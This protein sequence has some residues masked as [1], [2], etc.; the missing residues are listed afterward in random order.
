MRVPVKLLGFGFWLL[1]LN[2]AQCKEITCELKSTT[3]GVKKINPD[4]KIIFRAR[5][6]VEITC[7]EKHWIFFT[8]ESR[9]TF[10]CKADGKWDNEPVCAE[11]TCD[12]PRDQLVSRPYYWRT[13]K[14][15]EK[16]SYTCVNGYRGTEAEATCT[17]DGWTPKPLCTE[18]LCD[19]PKIKNA[20]IVGRQRPNY[21]I[22]S[23]EE[24]RCLSGFKPEKPVQITCDSQGQWKDIQQCIEITCELKST[25]I[26]VKKIN[27]DG[28]IIFRARESVEITCSEKH[29]IFFTKE[30]R[31]TFTC[32]ADGKWDN[33]PVCA[34]ITCDDPRDQ[35][36]SRPYYWRTMKFGEKQSYTCVNGYRGTEAEATCT[37]DGWTPKPLCT[38]IL[39]DVPKIK[40]A[41]IVGRQRP[42]YRINSK[43]EYRCLSGFKPEKPVQITCDSQGQ[44][45]DIQQCIEIMCDLPKITNAEIMRSQES[46]YKISS[47]VEYKCRSGFEPEK[48]VQI[49]CDSQGQWRGI[50]QCTE[51][52]CDLPKILNAEIL[53]SQKSNFKINSTTKYKCRSGIDAEKPIQITCDS[54]GQ[55]TGIQQCTEKCGPPP[56]ISNADTKEM[57]NKDYN[58]TEKVEYK[59]FDKYTMNLSPPFSKYLTCVKGEWK[60]DIYCFKPCIVTVEEMDKRGIRMRWKAN[61]KM[62]IPHNDAIDFLCKSGKEF[63]STC[64]DGVMLLPECGE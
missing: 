14:L 6:S 36:V 17:R 51:I 20:E 43:E 22:N 7:S 55:W 27:P 54:Q 5:E 2:F 58:T 38:E 12:D 32:K 4:G 45:K 13:M 57:T 48:P 3:I 56:E 46:N 28:K 37:R 41:E 31:K 40:N 34:E 53:G 24:Y 21:R 39:C 18:I 49:T 26:G 23:K 29:W 50:K 61:E 15:G 25:T 63:R 8:K 47:K 10:T 19:V 9:K 11:I 30:S 1:S 60:G 42:N 59:C 62:I 52:M 33:E 16:Q 35:L 44:W 64:K